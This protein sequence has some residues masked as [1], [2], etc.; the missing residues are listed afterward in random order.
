[1]NKSSRPQVL[2]LFFRVWVLQY[3]KSEWTL[4]LG[5]IHTLTQGPTLFLTHP[6][7]SNFVII[8][9]IR[10]AAQERRLGGAEG[11]SAPRPSGLCSVFCF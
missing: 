11:E 6:Q 5:V 3:S 1:M 10:Q 8:I 9:P 4:L 7:H 2:F